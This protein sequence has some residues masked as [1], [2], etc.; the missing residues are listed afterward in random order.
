MYRMVSS[1]RLHFAWGSSIGARNGLLRL[2]I[3]TT[4]NF[5]I[6]SF[7][8]QFFNHLQKYTAN[9]EYF[10]KNKQE[11]AIGVAGGGFAKE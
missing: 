6:P 8:E 4:R 3:L 2:T 11:G 10:F 9:H 7:V 5:F 1:H